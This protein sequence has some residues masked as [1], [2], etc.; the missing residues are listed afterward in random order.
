VY[1]SF[2]PRLFYVRNMFFLMLRYWP[3]SGLSGLVSK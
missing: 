1:G 3:V 2:V